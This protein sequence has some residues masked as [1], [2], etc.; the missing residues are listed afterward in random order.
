[1]LRRGDTVLMPKYADATPHLWILLTEP[2]GNGDVVIVNVTSL[3]NHPDQT[4]ILRVGDHSY[5]KHD[6]VVLYADARIV[7]AIPIVDGLKM[8]IPLFRKLD[9]CS[10]E[11]LNRICKGVF[12]SD[13]TPNKV[14]NFCSKQ[15][16]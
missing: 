8:N 7:S 1:M 13:F 15:W 12:A 14:I 6:S 9:P 11:L 10:D 2:D 5:I 16:N 4:T 3:K